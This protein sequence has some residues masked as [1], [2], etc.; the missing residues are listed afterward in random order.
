[1]LH[2]DLDRITAFTPVRQVACPS[3][4]RAVED[5]VPSLRVA[6][7][8][9]EVRSVACPSSCRTVEDL[10]PSLRVAPTES[11]GRVARH[12]LHGAEAPVRWGVATREG[13]CRLAGRAVGDVL[14]RLRHQ[15]RAAEHGR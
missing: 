15:D 10:V 9:S 13:P 5:L 8:E 7:T 12:A 4:C 1:M 14:A 3:S 2:A 11:R 6:L